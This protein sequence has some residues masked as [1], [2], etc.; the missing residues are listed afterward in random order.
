MVDL[1]TGSAALVHCLS[2][3]K[4]ETT[5]SLLPHLSRRSASSQDQRVLHMLWQ[6]ASE[7]ATLSPTSINR[8]ISSSVGLRILS[9]WSVRDN[10]FTQ[11]SEQPLYS[12]P[13]LFLVGLQTDS[14]RESTS[15]PTS[16]IPPHNR[17][18]QKRQISIEWRSKCVSHKSIPFYSQFFMNL[19]LSC[20][21]HMDKVRWVDR[22]LLV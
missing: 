9:G 14:P 11:S 17:F 8:L 3:D 22:G 21:L 7:L 19:Y 13:S 20:S 2:S 12:K 6:S 18:L 16:S 4:P 15:H 5:F 10:Y 1:C